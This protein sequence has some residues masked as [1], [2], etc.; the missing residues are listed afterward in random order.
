M[1]TVRS[2]GMAKEK[3]W[4]VLIPIGFNLL[5]LGILPQLLREQD[6]ARAILLAVAALVCPWVLYFIIGRVISHI[7]TRTKA[8][9]QPVDDSDF[10]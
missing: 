6:I 3:S 5:V 10:V 9:H 2:L 8:E 7:V 1:T 4:F